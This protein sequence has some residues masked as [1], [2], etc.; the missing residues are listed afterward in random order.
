MLYL[1]Y[2]VELE[3]AKA[4]HLEGHADGVRTFAQSNA[5]GGNDGGFVEGHGEGP[6]LGYF[7]EGND[8][9]SQV[10]GAGLQGKFPAV[11]G[12]G[13]EAAGLAGSQ[14]IENLK[15]HARIGV[16][17]AAFHVEATKYEAGY[18]YHQFVSP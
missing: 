7:L 12:E 11:Y 3:N 6:V 2:E 18:G 17:K 16:A 5:V 15:L 10:K 14:L 13:K 9:I 4:A 8:V 1:V